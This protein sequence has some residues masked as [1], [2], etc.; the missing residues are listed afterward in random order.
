MSLA[1]KNWWIFALLLLPGALAVIIFYVLEMPELSFLIL[2]MVV[3]ASLN[4]LG[5]LA[6]LAK[7]WPMI[8]EIVDW[9]KLE[10]IHDRNNIS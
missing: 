1:K 6:R 8:E 9:K 3:G 10:A 4:I 2:G 5:Y 7:T